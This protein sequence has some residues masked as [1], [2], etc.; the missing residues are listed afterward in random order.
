VFSE[1][2][3]RIASLRACEEFKKKK[4]KKNDV[5]KG[6]KNDVLPIDFLH[7]N[8]ARARQQATAASLSPHAGKLDPPGAVNTQ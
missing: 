4:K 1:G 3:S 7:T 8:L 5:G 6:G 2:S